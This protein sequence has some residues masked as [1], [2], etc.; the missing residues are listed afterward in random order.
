LVTHPLKTAAL[1]VFEGS[2]V[3]DV[4][5]LAHPEMMLFVL[6]YTSFL[7]YGVGT[8]WYT[9]LRWIRFIQVKRIKPMFNIIHSIFEY[10]NA[11]LYVDT[12]INFI[13]KK[14]NVRIKF[15]LSLSIYVDLFCM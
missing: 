4:L 13:N 8:T 11:V 9:K 6:G 14:K 2:F 7:G 15:V 5:L 12:Y 3:F 1:Y 10:R